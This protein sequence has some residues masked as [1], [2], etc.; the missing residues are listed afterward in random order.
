MVTPIF[1]AEY[2]YVLHLAS[3]HFAPLV[4]IRQRLV[5]A[6]NPVV[7]PLSWLRDVLE[8]ESAVPQTLP[9]ALVH[10]PSNL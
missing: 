1:G 6:S 2:R 4:S 9:P 7:A 8:P 10:S 5:L 3:C